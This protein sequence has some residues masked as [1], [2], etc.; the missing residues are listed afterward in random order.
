[1][2]DMSTHHLSQTGAHIIQ[3]EFVKQEGHD[4]PLSLI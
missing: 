2:E 4:D 1:M 3:K